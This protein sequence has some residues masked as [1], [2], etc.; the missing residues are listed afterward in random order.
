VEAV[1]ASVPARSNSESSETS[2]TPPQLIPV[3]SSQQKQQQRGIYYT[4]LCAQTG[5]YTDPTTGACSN[6]S[7]PASYACAYGA[8]AAC[9][10][11]PSGAL[12]PGGFRLWP[13]PGYWVPTET[14]GAVSAC[15]PPE[16]AAR[17]PGWG[18]AAAVSEDGSVSACGVGYLSG[19]Y[20]CSVCSPAFY[21]SD[22]GSC[23]ACPVITGAWDRYRGLLLLVAGLV[24]FLLAVGVCLILLLRWVGGSLA[25]SV[26]QLLQLGVWAW[27]TLQ[28]LSQVTRVSSRS[29]PGL[30]AALYRGVAVLQFAGIVLPPACTGA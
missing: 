1:L 6:A 9:V 12:C 4:L 19:S 2:T 23:A 28:T 5:L 29:L 11:C 3:Q 7:D 16:P 10:D 15:P 26:A 20:L 17:C 27:Q 18:T 22:D 30:I 8:G 14:A 13:R 21:G 25:G 24:G